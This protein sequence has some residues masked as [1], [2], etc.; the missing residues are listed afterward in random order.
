M[1]D[2]LNKKENDFLKIFLN[3]D[4]NSSFDVR[5]IE[6]ETKNNDNFR[7]VLFTGKNIQLVLMS[8]NPN[9]EIGNE[10]HNDTDQFFRIDEGEGKVIINNDEEIN[11]KD[12]SSII[13]GMGVYHNIINTSS[14]KKLKLYSL[15]TPPHH[16][17]GT[18]H[19]T[20]QDAIK[21]E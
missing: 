13:I 5:N 1:L 4:N 21:D 8:L 9:E 7:K 12:G 6:D 3:E 16:P 15:Y 14:T 17:E 20:K 11:I 10:V 2:I 19:K 18:I